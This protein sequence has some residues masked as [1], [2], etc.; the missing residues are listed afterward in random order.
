MERCRWLQKSERRLAKAHVAARPAQTP[1]YKPTRKIQKGTSQFWETQA[2][3]IN[4]KDVPLLQPQMPNLLVPEFEFLKHKPSS[5]YPHSRLEFYCCRASAL[6]AARNPTASSQGLMPAAATRASALRNTELLSP[7]V[8]VPRRE[9]R[10][11][12]L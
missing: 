11:M 10:A 8:M 12:G 6:P 2:K 3:K 1:F 4:Q 7:T 9:L 5:N